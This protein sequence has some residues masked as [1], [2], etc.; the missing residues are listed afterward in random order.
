MNSIRPMTLKDLEP[1]MAIEESCFEQAW[2]RESFVYEIMINQ[3]AQY[4][5]FEWDSNVVGYVGIWLLETEIHITNLAVVPLLR[6]QGIA[7]KLLEFVEEYGK[8]LKYSHFSLEVRENNDKA[9]Q[10]YEKLGY[11]KTKILNGY[12]KDQDGVLMEKKE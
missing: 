2:T 11:N 5:V 10:L 9:I 1:V 12:Y 8:K 3:V 4:F 7:T 6:R